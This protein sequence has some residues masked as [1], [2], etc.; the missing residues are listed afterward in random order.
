MGF[1]FVF[2]AVG[3]TAGSSIIAISWTTFLVMIAASI[4]ASLM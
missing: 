3:Q 4:F 2:T 1:N